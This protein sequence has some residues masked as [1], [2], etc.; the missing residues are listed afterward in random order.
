VSDQSRRLQI[1]ENLNFQRHQL[2]FERIGWAVM[3]VLLLAALLGLLGNGPLSSATADDGP[4]EV[5]Y[6]RL[7]HK[8]NTTSFSVSVE[9][10]AATGSEVR[11]WLEAEWATAFV[12]ESIA[13]E[14]ESVQV[15]PDRLL[16]VFAAQPG[17]QP[18]EIVFH[19][20][21]ERWGWLS[22]EIGLEGGPAVTLSQ[23]VY[24]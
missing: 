20:Q 8:A 1:E 4:L 11:V 17:E 16:Y 2:R 9:P 6:G 18:V 10:D 24:P 13:P 19:V 3:A 22:G 12:I 23:F 14:P 5:R 7:E 15:E 21:Y